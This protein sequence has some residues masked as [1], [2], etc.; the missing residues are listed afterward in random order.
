MQRW[1]DE[2]REANERM[3]VNDIYIFVWI[4]RSLLLLVP[5]DCFTLLLWISCD[6][7]EG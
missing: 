3:L 5:H 6:C 2:K 4:K 1:K 7:F